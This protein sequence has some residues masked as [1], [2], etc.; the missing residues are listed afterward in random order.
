[1]YTLIDDK[2]LQAVI[3]VGGDDRGALAL[4]RLAPA[5]LEE[6][7][8]DMLLVINGYRPLTR[9]V[10]E[11]LQVIAEIESA[12]KIPF[13]G[14]IN[15]SN[16]GAETTP[17]DVLASQ[18]LAQQVAEQTGLPLVMT[19][20]DASLFDQLQ[21]FIPHLFPLQLQRRAV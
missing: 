19:T 6:N 1:M 15:N 2:F 20:V 8:Y 18:V 11:V 10:D 5:I 17:D 4:G 14:I 13:T 12:G 9:T 16:L 7:N 21:E 3:D